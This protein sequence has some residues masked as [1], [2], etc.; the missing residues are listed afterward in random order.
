MKRNIKYLGLVTFAVVLIFQSCKKETNEIILNENNLNEPAEN[1]I[2]DESQSTSHRLGIRL[3]NFPGGAVTYSASFTIDSKIYAVGYKDFSGSKDLWIWDYSKV[4]NDSD[5]GQ[6][7]W[8]KLTDFPGSSPQGISLGF[9]VNGKGYVLPNAFIQNEN[10]VQEFWEFDPETNAWTKKS[11]PPATL[12]R[13]S[14]CGFSI[15]T[16]LYIGTGEI[17][18]PVWT[19]YKD[20]WEWE[21]TTDTWTKKADFPGEPRAHASGFSIGD[22]GYMGLGGVVGMGGG[23]VYQDFW[24]YDPATDKWIRKAD[25]PGSQQIGAVAFSAGNK[26]YVTAG[27]DIYAESTSYQDIWEWNQ[28]ENSWTM[29]G[30][31]TGTPRTGAVGGS[32]GNWGY[33]IGGQNIST[34]Y[35]WDTESVLNDFWLIDFTSN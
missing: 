34:G 18:E 13:S 28:T 10:L 1:I 3:Y 7:N 31:F 29:V 12:I 22:K 5:M 4:E 19:L 6:N 14:A 30:Y 33:V 20:F 23:P 24:E 17:Y 27:W 26:G 25:F 32:I 35:N 9:S 15:G 2:S 16:K 21:Q 8:S 11:N